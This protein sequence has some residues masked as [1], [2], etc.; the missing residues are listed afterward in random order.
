MATLIKLKSE[1]EAATGTLLK[2]TFAGGA[3]AHLLAHEIS[4]A[5]IGVI[6]ILSRT[7]TPGLWEG[8]R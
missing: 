5:G 7:G 6:L 3:E 2:I 8:R 1:V 4:S